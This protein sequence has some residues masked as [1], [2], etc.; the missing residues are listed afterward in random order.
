VGKELVHFG[1]EDD[2][3]WPQVVLVA[4]RCVWCKAGLDNRRIVVDA[5]SLGET[6]NLQSRELGWWHGICRPEVGKAWSWI[7]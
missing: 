6:R 2:E 3:L 1:A 7:C 4:V 5:R